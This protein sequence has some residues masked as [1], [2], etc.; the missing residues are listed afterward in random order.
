[1]PR[2]PR[3]YAV[4]H[5]TISRPSIGP[6]PDLDNAARIVHDG[7]CEVP[8]PAVAAPQRQRGKVSGPDRKFEE[9]MTNCFRDAPRGEQA[10]WL[11]I[12]LGTLL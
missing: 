9:L 3:A 11:N 10:R 1:M 6:I 5:G 2:A 8:A 12:L 7:G 4:I